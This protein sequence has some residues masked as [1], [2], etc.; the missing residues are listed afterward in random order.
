MWP[1]CSATQQRSLDAVA[2]ATAAVTPRPPLDLR[3]RPS[4][5]LHVDLFLAA[6]GTSI[7]FCCCTRKAACGC[8]ARQ[9]LHADASANCAGQQP[10]SHACTC[11]AALP[12]LLFVLVLLGGALAASAGAFCLQ[13][14]W[15][16]CGLHVSQHAALLRRC[17]LATLAAGRGVR[18]SCLSCLHGLSCGVA[19]G[20][21]LCVL[22][23]LQAGEGA[24]PD[25]V[26][27]C[28]LSCWECT[29]ACNT[30]SWH[31]WHCG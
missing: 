18:R 1:Q 2:A 26:L 5:K 31:S 21:E 24:A 12:G 9:P 30:N 13:A 16:G 7:C 10:H 27:A 19:Q 3:P 25:S 23:S 14:S 28:R 29:H 8:C 15:V 20:L 6:A 11:R 4:T 22:L 17:V